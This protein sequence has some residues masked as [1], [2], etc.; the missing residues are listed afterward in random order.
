MRDVAV[1]AQGEIIHR[2]PQLLMGYWNKPEET[3]EAFAGGWFHSGDVGYMDEGGYIFVVDRVKD[4]IKSGGVVVAGREVEEVLFKH[5]SVS[6]VAV[7]GLPDPKWIEAVT[8]IVVLRPG[9]EPDEASLVA[10]ARE[11]LA[12]FKVPKQFFFT[13]TLPRNTAGK[14][15]KRELRITYAEAGS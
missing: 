14:L 9:F 13:A 10:H 2:S 5:P 4:I 12:P 3:T 7:I 8:A 6:E 15:L 11:H 1:G